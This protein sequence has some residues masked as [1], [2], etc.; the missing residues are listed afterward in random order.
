MFLS[1]FHYFELALLPFF[2]FWSFLCF[3]LLGLFLGTSSSE[4][5]AS[6]CGTSATSV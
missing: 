2:F 1:P 5:I 4:G 6:V 3:I